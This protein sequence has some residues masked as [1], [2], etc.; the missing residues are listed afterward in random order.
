MAKVGH[1]V[2]NVASTCLIPAKILPTRKDGS[3][4]RLGQNA[5]NFFALVPLN[6]YLAILHR[7]ADSTSLLH[8]PRQ[9]LFFR[10]TDADE[11]SNHSDSFATTPCFLSNDIH[12][13]ATL[14]LC[15]CRTL[16]LCVRR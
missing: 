8:R 13:P 14:V 7:A 3:E 6:L 12:A 4:S 15:C 2:F 11:S 9:A 1:R 16:L 10:Q 5:S